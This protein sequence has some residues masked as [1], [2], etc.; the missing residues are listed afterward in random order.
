MSHMAP[1]KLFSG[2]EPTLGKVK[3]RGILAPPGMQFGAILR[4]DPPQLSGEIMGYRARPSGRTPCFCVIAS[5][6]RNRDTALGEEQARTHAARFEAGT[7]HEPW[8]PRGRTLTNHNDLAPRLDASTPLC[9]A[10]RGDRLRMKR[11]VDT[12]EDVAVCEQWGTGARD[13]GM[14]T[15]QVL[16]R[17]RHQ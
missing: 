7:R 2:S 5:C 8:S 14:A 16:M 6:L 11:R 4:L 3:S 1:S 10:F 15:S 13:A 12:E 17:E 9:E